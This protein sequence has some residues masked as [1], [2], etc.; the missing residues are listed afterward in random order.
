MSW[1]RW[2]R[3]G[4]PQAT[5]ESRGNHGV[6]LPAV[7]DEVPLCQRRWPETSP[8]ESR[9]RKQLQGAGAAAVGFLAFRTLQAM[10]PDTGVQSWQ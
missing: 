8:A 5:G 4:H 9:I 3:P 6:P 1:R 2:M 7:Q 10:G